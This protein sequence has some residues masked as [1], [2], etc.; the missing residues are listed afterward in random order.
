MRYKFKDKIIGP[1][2]FNSSPYFSAHVH[3]NY[4]I[5]DGMSKV[6]YIVQRAAEYGQPGIALTD[7]GL[8]SGNV[9]LYRYS[10]QYGILPFPGIEQYIIDPAYDLSNLEDGDKAKEVQ[11]YHLGM[12]AL[13]R[14]G[15]E[16]LVKSSTLSFTRPRFHRF[17]RLLINDLVEFGQEYGDN[18]FITTGCIFGLVE[19]NLTEYGIEKAEGIIRLLQSVFPNL[20]VELQRHGI[21]DGHNEMPEQEVLDTMLDIADRFSLPIIATPDSHYLEES[22]K[23]AHNLMKR[24]IYRSM[25]D[26]FPGDSYHLPSTGW[27]RDKYDADVWSRVEESCNDLINKHRLEIK[28]LDS[29]K[30]YIPKMADNPDETLRKLCYASL[31]KLNLS[32]KPEYIDR[33]E[34]ELRVFKKIQMAD[35]VLLVK[36]SVDY[37]RSRKVPIEA[38]GSG[39]GSLVLYLLNV[40]QVD[41]I[42]WDTDFTRFVS[43]D[44]LDAPDVDIDIATDGR[45]I[46]LEYLDGLEIR[47]VTYKTSQIGT[48]GH[49][50]QSDKDENDAGSAFNSYISYL[51]GKYKDEAWDKEKAR[52]ER[53]ERKPVRYKADESGAIMFNASDDV[54]IKKLEDVKIIHP[55]DY[56]GLRE[57]INMK[58]V[59]KSKGTHAGGILVSSQ[60][61]KLEDIVPLMLIPGTKKDTV[62]TQYTMKEVA[63]FGLLK[64]D[65]LGQTSLSVMV[66]CQE[67]MGREDPLDFTWIPF[68]DSMTLKYVSI[69]K[70]HPGLFHLENYP[71]SVAMA[72]LKPTTT[73]DFMIHQAYSMPGA[74][75]SGAKDIYLERRTASSW[76]AD[77]QHSDLHDIFDTTNG[78]MLFQE[79]VLRVCRSVGFN[80]EE[81]TSVFSLIK[82]S[83]SGSRERNLQRL[84][85]VKPRFVELAINNNFTEYEIE[86]LW[87]QII[88][89]GG[90][91][92][93]KAHA[94]GYG[95]RSYRTAYLK[96]HYPVE[97]MA[98]LLSCWAGSSTTVGIGKRKIKKEDA[99]LNEVKRMGL[100]VLPARINRSKDNW[101][102]DSVRKDLRKGYLSVSG[103]G[104]AAATEID[105]NQP[106]TS[107]LD[108]AQRTKISGSPAYLKDQSMKGAIAKLDAI[109]AL[110]FED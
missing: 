77:Y 14:R 107:L 47:G 63:R 67:F 36:D 54:N 69:R 41:P 65:W 7:H 110:E 22:H 50:G 30:P 92:F 52:A 33:L 18:V 11:R 53:E 101:S 35:Y 84:S 59:Y 42:I 85:E 21:E 17:P 71:K 89:M 2:S 8:M 100:R 99:Y 95:I 94:A 49:L 61:V 55:E 29:F 96:C 1:S 9:E 19:R 38:R 43:E 6:E 97:Y 108:L 32:D 70:N 68:D 82:D 87:H 27:M 13:D 90:Y 28:E 31:N 15:Y 93:N 80:G 109:G 83:G 91:S 72:E 81:L 48:F 79:Q 64:M 58:S 25:E 16:G 62:V 45:W 104:P 106:Y 44:R 75:D 78:V 39:N 56:D 37:V 10:K 88:A 40:T 51:K 12:V 3:S 57:I 102:V 5:V 105:A 73:H 60:D 20:Y 86:W 98:A 46:I 34:E 103:I 74:V 26:D 66:K 23:S 76:E 4:S 24:M